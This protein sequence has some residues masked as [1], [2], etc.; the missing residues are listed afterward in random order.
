MILAAVADAQLL[1][2]KF[3]AGRWMFLIGS[4]VPEGRAAPVSQIEHFFF[5]PAAKS[6]ESTCTV[7]AFVVN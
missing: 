5:K 6:S 4:A 2:P 7:A 3:E 1:L